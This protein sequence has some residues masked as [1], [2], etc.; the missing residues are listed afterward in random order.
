MLVIIFFI[1][2]QFY[3]HLCRGYM[4]AHAGHWRLPY[5]CLQLRWHLF[6]LL[7][8]QAVVSLEKSG[9]VDIPLQSAAVPPRASHP[10]L[11][12]RSD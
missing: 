2:H 5:L 8:S 10:S 9:P 4:T 3:S 11:T 1:M 6:K 12:S 7:T